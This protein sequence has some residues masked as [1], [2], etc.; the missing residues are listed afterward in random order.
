MS[1]LEDQ[2]ISHYNEEYFE[3]QSGIGEFGGWANLTKFEQ[4]VSEDDIV[5][6]FGCG[7]G[8]LLSNINCA[9]RIGIEINPHAAKK[10]KEF[11]IEVYDDINKIE[12]ETADIIISNS[13]LE[14]V[15]QPL[16]ILK[17][18]HKKLKKGGKIIFTVPCESI[19]Y[20]YK[21]NDINRHIYTWSPMNLGNL[22]DEAGFAVIESKPYK[23]K[24]PPRADLYGRFLGHFL[25][26]ILCSVYDRVRRYSSQVRLV[27]LKN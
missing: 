8:Y 14:H 1:T 12:D 7:G 15:H 24:W 20:A 16:D 18:L 26:N 22:F 11:G 6:D 3:W 13:A 9:K 23:H 25:F 27:A 10:A 21:P 4:Y 19:H 2:N 5:L 17:L